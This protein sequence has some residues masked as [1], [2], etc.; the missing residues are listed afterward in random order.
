MS[1]RSQIYWL[2]KPATLGA[3]LG[4]TLFLGTSA[5][6]SE[7]PQPTSTIASQAGTPVQLS[8]IETAGLEPSKSESFLPEG[9][10]QEQP[11]D[12]L[13]QIE[14]YNPVNL[15]LQGEDPLFEVNSVNEL[16]DV[17][18][19]DWAYSALRGLAERYG[20]LLAYRDGT[21]RGNRAMTRYEF[22]ASLDACM[23]VM[24]RFIEE[25]TSEIGSGD[26][27][28][29]ARLQE[30]FAAELATM[31][32]R[33]DGL[34]VRTA[35]LEANQFSTT[36]KLVGEATWALANA[37]GEDSDAQTVF[38]QK[39]RLNF[40]SS[41][42]GKDKLITRLEFGNFGPSFRGE[43]GTNEGR[44]AF[45]G[46]NNNVVN[47]NVLHYIMPVSENLTARIF[48][49]VGGHHFYA[50]T[51]NPFLEAGGGGGG[52]LSRFGE[53]NPIFRFNLGGKGIGFKYKFNEAVEFDVG[54][55]A[56]EAQFSRQGDGLFNG[57]Y[58]ALA[59]LVINAGDRVKLGL[60][61]INGYDGSDRRFGFGGTGTNLGNLN[62][63]SL[64]VPSTPV[65]SNSYGVQTS[66]KLTPNLILGGWVGKTSA[67][68]IGLGD[69]DIWNYAVTLAMPDLGKKGSVG[70]LVVGAEP[71]LTDLDIPGD[72]TFPDDTPLHIEGFYK[73]QMTKNI[74]ITPGFIWLTAPNQDNNNND[75][76]IGTLRTTFKF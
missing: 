47:L 14:E 71:H 20:C 35:E 31:R 27:D 13:E 66:L 17:R 53:R 19:T 42:T 58:S 10:A 9:A 44:F 2:T 69:A 52:A 41:F 22:A 50:P 48:A 15:S 5:L 64:N 18:P 51:L 49:N 28:V 34:E 76:V 65:S 73:Y 38:S 16:S 25:A 61:Y 56:N 62:L 68:L 72:P 30:E 1:K 54:Y 70:G 57:N 32:A 21:Y 75:V 67:R 23:N 43:I 24:Q 63:S 4:A 59:Q 40:V 74:A 26:L 46:A 7:E 6:A 36:T 11:L 45:D 12:L 60:T 8:E 37:F 33:V 55:L 3:T 39:V 29:I